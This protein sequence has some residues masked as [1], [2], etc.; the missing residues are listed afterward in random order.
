MD[1]YNAIK[2]DDFF[3]GIKMEKEKSDIVDSFSNSIFE[4]LSTNKF[5][6]DYKLT[7]R[8]DL[9]TDV[10]SDITYINLTESNFEHIM[11]SK[12]NETSKIYIKTCEK[13]SNKIEEH[14]CLPNKMFATLKKL[15]D[16]SENLV[17][18]IKNKFQDYLTSI[19]DSN[20][21][22]TTLNFNSNIDISSIDM[23]YLLG[24]V[25]ITYNYSN[26]EEQKIEQSIPNKIF[27]HISVEI[28]KKISIRKIQNLN[29]I[30]SELNNVFVSSIILNDD[31]DMIQINTRGLKNK[32]NFEIYYGNGNYD[33]IEYN[34]NIENEC[35]KEIEA[36][37]VI[38]FCNNFF[39]K[40]AKK[41]YDLYNEICKYEENTLVQ[42]NMNKD[43]INVEFNFPLS[44]I[45]GEITCN[46]VDNNYQL[47]LYGRNGSYAGCK[48]F[49]DVKELFKIINDILEKNKAHGIDI[50]KSKSK[51]FSIK[52]NLAI[53]VL[54]SE[55]D[56]LKIKKFLDS[57][58]SLVKEDI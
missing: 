3:T 4:K 51:L 58:D 52:D 55:E 57:G 32:T 17:V 56:I 48:G 6:D 26:G 37:D 2:S 39:N 10:I 20:N 19:D 22:K 49:N 43:I 30:I 41:L 21:Y 1:I 47:D 23:C 33:I 42:F 5:F 7:D 36:K 38:V 34:F 18:L 44:S 46:Y 13:F 50:D 40:N 45:S 11:V 12:H 28:K 16:D 54:E 24:Y 25:K 8:R 29:D 14:F 35:Y 53:L 27:L 31:K 15:I 9:D